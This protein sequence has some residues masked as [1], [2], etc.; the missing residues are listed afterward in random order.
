MLSF[1]VVLNLVNSILSLTIH[2]EFSSNVEYHVIGTPYRCE[3]K[4]LEVS[5]DDSVVTNIT[6][7]HEAGMSNSDVKLILIQEQ[8]IANIPENLSK[9]FPNIEGLIIDDSSL[10]T[11]SKSD[12]VNFPNL[13]LLFIGNNR[14]EKID[15]DLFEA[16]TELERLVFTN[17]FTRHIGR[18][19][20][21]PLSKLRFV[22]FDRNNCISIKAANI[23]D[24]E[25]LSNEI[26][27]RCK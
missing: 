27:K 11:I 24:I 10:K 18:G 2:C 25:H 3:V 1:L 9:F 14:I 21:S 7:T 19:I 4:D 16:C 17:N 13:K 20:L 6:G 23:D 8:K 5:S 22:S 15:G 12:L 26:L